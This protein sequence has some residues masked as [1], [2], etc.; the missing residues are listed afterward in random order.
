[1]YNITFICTVHKRNGKCN[2]RKLRKIIEEFNPEVI[3][4]ELSPAVYDEC[5]GIKNRPTL[6]TR[7]IKK[8]LRKHIIKHI[9]VVGTELDIESML[10]IMEQEKN[11]DYQ[12]LIANLTSSENKYGFQFLNSKQCEDL[13]EKMR[14]LER[15]ILRD[16]DD[17]VWARI[18]Q[19]NREAIE[20]YENT[21]IKNIY[22]YSEENKYNNALMFI[23]AAHRRSII[24]KIQEYQKNEKIELNWTF[25]GKSEL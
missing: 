10:K 15:K 1:M 5:Y 23:G 11:T 9:P 2:S 3:F 22:A 18:Y 19:R 4:E 16:G 21:I 17:V 13:C 25:Y 7:A 14:M 6:E 12:K 20:T 8:Y 24:Q